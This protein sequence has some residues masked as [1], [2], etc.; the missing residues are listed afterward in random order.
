[1]QELAQWL[2]ST[3]LGLAIHNSAWLFPFIEIFHLLALGLLG[4]TVMLVDLRMLGM[5]FGSK[6][7]PDLARE[8]RPWL[9]LSLWVILGSGW[10]LFTSEAVQM[11]SN[12]AF[13]LKMLFLFLAIVFTF[14]IR[15]KVINRQEVTPSPISGKLTALLSMTLWLCVGLGGRAIGFV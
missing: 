13:R 11:Y 8:V 15:Q 12:Q 4:G 10:L 2:G 7:A 6:T 5:A 3:Q 1:M 14:T 9:M